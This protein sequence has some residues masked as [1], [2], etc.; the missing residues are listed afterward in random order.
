MLFRFFPQEINFFDLL[1]AQVDSAVEA[2]RY[3][4]E[5]TDK[6]AGV[7]ELTRGKMQSIEKYGDKAAHRVIQELNKTFITPFDREDIHS[8]A[9]E[10]DNITDMV[11]NIV[12]RMKVY[13]LS[14]KDEHIGEFAKVIERSVLLVSEAVKGLKDAKNFNQVLKACAEINNLENVGD[15]MRDNILAELFETE[16]NPISLIKW[17][18]V[19]E[20]AETVLD[21]CE[22]AAHVVESIIVKQA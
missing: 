21:L 12:S 4:K 2:A 20:N 10:I 7:D 14:P 9:K 19:Y 6:N 1:D 8:L 5:I 3:F 18:E 22:D 11:N 13:K 17:K 16:K 15:S